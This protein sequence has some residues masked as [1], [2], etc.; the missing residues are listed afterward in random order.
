MMQEGVQCELILTKN[1][2][3]CNV[4]VVTCNVDQESKHGETI[5]NN[6]FDSIP[7]NFI[8]DKIYPNKS[9]YTVKNNCPII[10]QGLQHMEVIDSYRF[11]S[12]VSTPGLNQ[13]C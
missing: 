7:S 3:Q 4:T 9:P 11:L 1:R 6:K 13:L 12:V 5:R 8:L 10:D 2:R